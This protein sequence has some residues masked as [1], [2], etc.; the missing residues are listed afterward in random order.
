MIL[1]LTF[2]LQFLKILPVMGKAG[3]DVA[4]IKI[5]T[6]VLLKCFLM[7]F[8]YATQSKIETWDRPQRKLWNMN[9]YR[10]KIEIKVC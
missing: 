8:S 4:F 2:G 10:S 5:A 3:K 7:I 6:C 1:K 9:P